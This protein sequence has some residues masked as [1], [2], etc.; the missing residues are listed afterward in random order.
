[1][2]NAP[3][4]ALGRARPSPSR[5]SLAASVTAQTVAAQKAMA[6]EKAAAEKA[7]VEKAAAEQA[8]VEK[9]AAEKAAAEKAAVEKAAAEKAAAD[10]AELEAKANAMAEQL[11]MEEEQ[12]KA[13]VSGKASKKA[14]K[15]KASGDEPGGSGD[16]LR[17]STDASKEPEPP[18][19]WSSGYMMWRSHAVSEE[20]FNPQKLVKPEFNKGAK[21]LYERQT[22]EYKAEWDAKHRA[23][24]ATHDAWK[25]A[26]GPP[27]PPPQFSEKELK[28]IYFE[29]LK[30][31]KDDPLGP[32]PRAQAAGCSA[33]AEVAAASDE[34]EPMDADAAG[35]AETCK[36]DSAPPSTSPSPPPSTAPEVAAAS[37]ATTTPAARPLLNGTHFIEVR[38]GGNDAER[39]SDEWIKDWKVHGRTRNSILKPSEKPTLVQEYAAS[40]AGRGRQG[41]A[42]K[43]EI[44]NITLDRTPD[45]PGKESDLRLLIHQANKNVGGPLWKKLALDMRINA[46]KK[47]DGSPAVRPTGGCGT[48]NGSAFTRVHPPGGSIGREHGDTKG[49]QTRVVSNDTPIECEPLE[50]E[51]RVHKEWKAGSALVSDHETATATIERNH[52]YAMP[53]KQSG[54]QPMRKGRYA[55]HQPKPLAVARL[56]DIDDLEAYDNDTAAAM[57]A[58]IVRTMIAYGVTEEDESAE[59]EWPEDIEWKLSAGGWRE[60]CKGDF[61][62]DLRARIQAAVNTTIETTWCEAGATLSELMGGQPSPWERRV[63]SR[64]GKRITRAFAKEA[65]RRQT[66]KRALQYGN[67]AVLDWEASMLAHP[68]EMFAFARE[69]EEGVSQQLVE[70][71]AA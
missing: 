29:E 3:Y 34:S 54:A 71:G 47:V 26:N 62:P 2:R 5:R 69:L 42:P 36:A 33:S 25:A 20:A 31:W 19:P 66:G 51:V 57:D 46:L 13:Q 10:M 22:A 61:S 35:V 11:I 28:S 9:A 52:Q 53:P 44:G 16:E 67:G 45:A 6:A 37:D 70:A 15:R 59:W 55:H 41:N 12:E 4:P 40:G 68:D 27:P 65:Y 43:G 49:K 32:L 58:E 38:D 60:G 56:S 24:K 8:A 17:S 30:D 39:F 18:R 14:G 7:A 21:D 64:V 23:V 63:K 48:R 1:M 50:L